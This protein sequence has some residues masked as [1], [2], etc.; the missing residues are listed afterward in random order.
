LHSEVAQVL[1]IH[2][3]QRNA[4]QD[5]YSGRQIFS[6]SA[7]KRTEEKKL[8]EVS[9]YDDNDTFNVHTKYI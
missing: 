9:L 8:Q 2:V 7:A 1:S 5:K 6:R 3:Y 4:K